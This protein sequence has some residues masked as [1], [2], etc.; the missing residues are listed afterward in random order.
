MKAPAFF[1]KIGYK[2]PENAANSAFQYGQNTTERPYEYLVERPE[3][4][5]RFNNYMGGRRDGEPNWSDA[6]FYPVEEILQGSELNAQSVLLV[7]VGGGLGHDA[8]N[9]KTKHPSLPGRIV[10]QDLS[11]SV[12][13]AA[14][15]GREIEMMSHDFF[16]PQPIQG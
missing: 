16:T 11:A 4:Q 15:K 9:F 13:Q 2:N 6:D 14:R 10:V 1:S 5:Q 12:E 8:E 7:D 3:L